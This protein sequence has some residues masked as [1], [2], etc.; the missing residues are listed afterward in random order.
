MYIH[1]KPLNTMHTHTHTHTHTHKHTHMYTHM[2]VHT[3]THTHACA[4]THMHTYTRTHAH[5]HTHTHTHVHTHTHT[6]AHIHTHTH[7]RHSPSS[8]S[9][10]LLRRESQSDRQGGH[11]WEVGRH[12]AHHHPPPHAPCQ[13]ARRLGVEGA[14]LRVLVRP[15]VS[16]RRHHHLP[17]QCGARGLALEAGRVRH[18]PYRH[19]GGPHA[20]HGHHGRRPQPGL[21]V[22]VERVAGATA[23]G[24][25]A[26]AIGLVEQ[27][28][29]GGV[30]HQR[31]V[32][33]R[34][35]L[36]EDALAERHEQHHTAPQ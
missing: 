10:G 16:C 24:L 1:K 5:T 12:A 18:W 2:Q 35:V 6:H 27:R 17:V 20:P 11:R 33:A 30:L 14:H 9:Q 36:V 34:V 15:R 28:G 26:R 13:D 7:T 4:H 29:R 21:R 32:T 23:Q 3:H 8:L 22:E 19:L 25:E 31:Q